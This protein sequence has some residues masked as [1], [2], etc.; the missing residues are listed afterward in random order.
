MDVPLAKYALEGGTR[1]VELNHVPQAPVFLDS[2]AERFR[3]Q[4]LGR[5]NEL[6]T[7][8]V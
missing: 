5:Q 2:I 4:A 3:Q 7:H 1:L 8:L 6:V